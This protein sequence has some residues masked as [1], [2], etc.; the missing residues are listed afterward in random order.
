MFEQ[1]MSKCGV[2]PNVDDT[3]QIVPNVDIRYQNN[4]KKESVR[5]LQLVFPFVFSKKTM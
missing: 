2:V 3:C 4:K 5:T 1:K